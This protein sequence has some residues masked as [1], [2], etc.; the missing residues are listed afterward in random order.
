M[1]KSEEIAEI[2]R[3]IKQLEEEV[4]Y[5]DEMLTIRR[6]QLQDEKEHLAELKGGWLNWNC[7]TMYMRIIQPEMTVACKCKTRLI[8]TPQDVIDDNA[9]GTYVPCPNCN[10]L[11]YLHNLE[12]A[13]ANLVKWDNLGH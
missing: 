8:I 11:I 13:F 3:K 6:R 2:Q 1:K 7:T 10:H 12:P 9:I 4:S 5:Y